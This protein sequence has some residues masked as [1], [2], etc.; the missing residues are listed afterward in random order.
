MLRAWIAD[1]LMVIAAVLAVAMLV[2]VLI[3]GF[4]ALLRLFGP[5]EKL[6]SFDPFGLAALANLW[7]DRFARWGIACFLGA[8]TAA[9]LSDQ[10]R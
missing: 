1:G 4:R 10:I 6:P 9:W 7:R 5:T 2:L 3:S 8:C